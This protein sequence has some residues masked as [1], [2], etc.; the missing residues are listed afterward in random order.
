MPTGAQL[1]PVEDALAALSL[2][3]H[4][5]LCTGALFVHVLDARLITQV[6]TIACTLAAARATVMARTITP[7]TTKSSF[8]AHHVPLRRLRLQ[9]P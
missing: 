1:A 4:V 8:S 9:R 5:L 3:L 2:P 6:A 7:W